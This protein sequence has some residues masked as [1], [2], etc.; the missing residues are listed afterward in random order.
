MHHSPLQLAARWLVVVLLHRAD[1]HAGYQ[2][3]IPNGR[4]VPGVP[5][6]PSNGWHGVGHVA[7]NPAS[8]PSYLLGGYPRNEFGLDFAQAGHRWTRELCLRD[9]DRDGLT[10]GQELGDPECVWKPGRPPARTHD[11]SH[12]GLSPKQLRAWSN[13]TLERQRARAARA[14]LS[15]DRLERPG[16]EWTN[17]GVEQKAFTAALFYYQYVMIPLLLLLSL[18][19]SCTRF[20]WKHAPLPHFWGV[21]ASYYVLF[22]CGVGLGVHRYFSHKAY[23]ASGPWKVVLCFLSLFVGQGGPVDWAYVHRIHHRICEHE[24]DYHS[25]HPMDQKGFWYGQALWMV[26]P[27][28]HVKRSPQLER[29]HCSDIIDDPDIKELVA[30]IGD[31][32]AL[33]KGF[34]GW[35]LPG[36]LFGAGF[37]VYRC[38]VKPWRA[39]RRAMA[40]PGSESAAAAKEA[41]RPPTLGQLLAGGLCCATYYFYLPVALTWMSTGFVNSATHIWGDQPFEDGMMKGCMAKNTAFLFIPM[42]GENWHNNHH[43]VPASLSTWVEW[44]QVDFLVIT[45]RVLEA[46][47]LVRDIRIEVPSKLLEPGK[48]PVG[49]PVALW[50]LWACIIASALQLRSMAHERWERQSTEAARAKVQSAG[51]GKH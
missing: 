12:P 48:G 50:T 15:P 2:D 29:Y 26:T 6:G 34:V 43:A 27:H 42:L 37:A 20:G 4:N 7:P 45:A 13:S 40:Q 32:P 5:G 9:S 28:M 47:G 38:L 18:S 31:N 11:V 41:A 14:G 21:F 39:R 3:S 22:I 10:N 24:L 51:R 49:L 33:A 8:H 1:G 44:Y 35:I 36:F 23:T 46:V 17:A 30:W 25:P 19:I 16:E